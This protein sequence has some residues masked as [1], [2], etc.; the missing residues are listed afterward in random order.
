VLAH[1]SR[2]GVQGHKRHNKAY[3]RQGEWFFVPVPDMDVRGLV[4]HQDEP[5]QRGRAKPHICEELIRKGGYVVWVHPQHAPEGVSKGEADKIMHANDRLRTMN[6]RLW[7]D[8]TTGWTE[9]V[10][11]AR[12]YVRGYVKHPDHKT[13]HLS[14]WCRVFANTEDK[15]VAGRESLRFLD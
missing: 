3:I 2:L 15:S 5:I 12:V 9:R 1:Q 14:V 7:R 8:S 4:I 6:G 13:V 10:A 11:E